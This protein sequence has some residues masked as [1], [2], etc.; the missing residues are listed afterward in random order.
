[1]ALKRED[2]MQ[3][4]SELGIPSETKDHAPLFTVEE[5]KALRGEIRG[6]HSK[7]LFLKDKKGAL[8]LVVAGED[9][10]IDLKRFHQ[11]IGSARLSFGK[12]DLLSEVL[13]VTP[14]TVSPFALINDRDQQVKIVLD[15]YLMAAEMANF[16]PLTNK[17]TTSIS[18]AGLLT[19]IA[20]CG[21]DPLIIDVQASEPV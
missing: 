10:E 9:A 1:M 13:G 19:F 6:A 8:Y 11:R 12:P 4:L 16:H 3:R 5:S 20:S 2:V 15:K 18:P 17:A 14:G 7:N 21:H